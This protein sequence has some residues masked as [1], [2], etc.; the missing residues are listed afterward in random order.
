MGKTKELFMLVREKLN[1]IDEEVLE[2]Q[3]D[4]D[5]PNCD[6]SKLVYLSNNELVCNGCAQQFDLVN[7]EVRFK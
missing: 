4:F 1:F 7:E 2:Y 6:N 5:C 3:S